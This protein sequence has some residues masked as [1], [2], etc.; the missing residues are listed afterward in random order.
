MK[1]R[2]KDN[3]KI[4]FVGFRDGAHSKNG[5]YD[6]ITRYGRGS[7]TLMLSD[8]PLGKISLQSPFVRIPL[9]LLDVFARIRRRRYSITHLIYGDVTMLRFL[10]Y[11]RSSRHKTAVTIHLDVEQRKFKK[12]FI[13]Q[14]RKM[15][16]V[17][18]LSSNY[19]HLLKDRYKIEAEFVPHGFN[20]PEYKTVEVRDLQG[21]VLD[22]KCINILTIG[23]MYRD[24]GLYQRLVRKYA[25]DDRFCFHL[26]GAPV[27]VRKLGEE[28]S[29]V[30]VY[31]RLDD[32]AYYSLI[33][34]CDYCFLPLSFATANNALLESQYLNTQLILPEISGVTDYAAPAPMN[35]FYNDEADLEKIINN[36]VKADK[37]NELSEFA[38]RFAWERIYDKLDE[39][40]TE[41]RNE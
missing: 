9:M 12:S 18:V 36:L 5:G 38:S 27:D 35:I 41:L 6:W 34:S 25:N 17:I 15:D 29:N 8:V 11:M 39:I 32:D 19:A 20:M 37:G 1:H 28:I 31:G 14:L 13:H 21:R 4:L 30:R 7:D 10:P 23:K 22:K 33:A 3:D 40:Y 2:Q 16:K 24:Y 26:V